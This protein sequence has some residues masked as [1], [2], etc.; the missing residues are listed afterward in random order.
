MEIK[1]KFIYSMVVV[2]LQ[3]SAAMG[4]GPAKA[5]NFTITSF[6]IKLYGQKQASTEAPTNEERNLALKNFIAKEVPHSDIYV[7]EEIMNKEDFQSK[8]VSEL[9]CV[10]YTNSR[11]EHQYVMLC[12]RAP[13]ELEVDTKVDDNYAIEEVALGSQGQRPAVHA[14][15]KNTKGKAVVRIIG[16]H[17]SAFPAN[18]SKRLEQIGL[19]R[20]HLAKTDQSIP[21]IITGDFNTYPAT[22][23]GLSRSDVELITEDLAQ[24]QINMPAHP[25]QYTF[26]SPSFR[27]KFDHF[28]KSQSLQSMPVIVTG[29]CNDPE[30]LEGDIAPSVFD[31]Y[32]LISDHCPVTLKVNL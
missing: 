13:Y 16:T 9:K 31:Y 21:T 15:V 10:S 19:I 20:A 17:L 11:T 22:L 32:R 12:A 14:L 2:C 18:T 23:T 1:S 30:E 27:S 24:G 29:Y 6:N 4:A 28:W 26:R 8:V 7:F 5:P 25:S 3:I